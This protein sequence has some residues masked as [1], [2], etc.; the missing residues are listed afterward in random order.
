[1][2][3]PEIDSY[4]KLMLH[5]DGAD[6]STTFTDSSASGHSITANGN[7]QIDTAQSKFGGAS[8][9]FDGTGDYITVPDHADWDFGS[10]DFTIDF[11]IRFAANQRHVIYNQ[12][13]Y[14]GTPSYVDF[15]AWNS[16]PSSW[17]FEAYDAGTMKCQYHFSWTPNNN[18]WYHVEIGRNGTNIYIFVDGVAQSLT[19]DVAVS[20]NSFPG[21][22][23]DLLIGGHTGAGLYL[24]GWLDE[25]R[26]SK[27][28]CRHTSNFTPKLGP[29]TSSSVSASPSPTKSPSPSATKSSSPSPTQSS[30]K[31]ASASPTKSASASPTPSSSKSSSASAS[32]SSSP[33]ETQSASLSPSPSAS[34]SVSASPSISPSAGGTL[35][36]LTYPTHIVHLRE[37]VVPEILSLE[38]P[39]ID[40]Y[41]VSTQYNG[42]LAFDYPLTEII[43]YAGGN[44]AVEVSKIDVSLIGWLLNIGSLVFD[45]P[46]I[47]VL[48]SGTAEEPF[49]VDITYPTITVA[50]TGYEVPIGALSFE[51]TD[52]DV[53]MTGEGGS[54]VVERLVFEFTDSDEGRGMRG[55][56]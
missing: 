38:Y 26:V 32:L 2:P 31:S 43:G 30:T 40:V 37:G 49:S 11:W 25:F 21:I 34:E 44:F 10:G 33:S 39:S 1:M 14:A 5:M 8:G 55:R 47:D 28:I 51:Y 56:F 16:T 7:A 17:G 15:M 22:T 23:A 3:A 35:T 20:T 41:L 50:L 42:D 45:F 52:I 36:S 53:F 46:F 6:G 29:Y 27:G 24:N 19:A 9:L 18:Q 4:V 12:N 13:D 48:V 54:K